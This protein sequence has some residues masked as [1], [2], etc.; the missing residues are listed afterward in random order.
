MYRGNEDS[1]SSIITWLN[2]NYYIVND[3]TFDLFCYIYA[4][5]DFGDWLP[6]IFNG[7][8]L[9]WRNESEKSSKINVKTIIS[10][11]FCYNRVFLIIF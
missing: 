6:F 3:I 11:F 8:R 4:R 9:K 7:A 1:M 5:K 10:D 2:R